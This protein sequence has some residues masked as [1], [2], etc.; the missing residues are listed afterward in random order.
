[1]IRRP[2]RATLAD[3]LF[4]YTTLVRSTPIHFSRCSAT[5]LQ[6]RALSGARGPGAWGCH[7]H[8][9]V[10]GFSISACANTGTG[11]A[12]SI[13]NAATEA[14]IIKVFMIPLLGLNV[15]WANRPRTRW[16]ARRAVQC[17]GGFAWRIQAKTLGGCDR[18]SVV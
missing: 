14:L 2:P 4:P 6:A 12:T 1:M 3:T 17:L 9:M 13:V 16:A 10:A 18:Q 7:S 11:A 5:F 15:P 8:L